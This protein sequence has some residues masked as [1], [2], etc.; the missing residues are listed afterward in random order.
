MAIYIALLP[1][2]ASGVS[3]SGHDAVLTYTRDQLLTLQTQ[4]RSWRRKT[5]R[6]KIK[7]RGSRGGVFE[8]LR[9]CGSRFPLPTITLSNVRSLNN[10]IEELTARLTHETDFQQCNLICLTDTRLKPETTVS[11]DGY[12]MIRA[13][14]DEHLSKKS[15]GG[16]LCILMDNK[17]TDLHPGL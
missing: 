17:R 14:R 15:I 1:H 4:V 3:T 12:A 5:Q 6:T 7:K 2:S 11:V 16:G 9:R 13:D 8:R 10:K